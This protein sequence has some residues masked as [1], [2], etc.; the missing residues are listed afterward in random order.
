[1]GGSAAP[2]SDEKAE[3]VGEA[4]IS[5]S[6]V[7]I[8]VCCRPEYLLLLNFVSARDRKIFEEKIFHLL[9]EDTQSP[10]Y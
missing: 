10:S 7:V 5:Q 3:Q 8:P 2:A 6:P 4:T 9:G 1:M